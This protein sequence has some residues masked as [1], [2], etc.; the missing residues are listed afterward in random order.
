[1]GENS[2]DPL[3]AMEPQYAT[4]MINIFPKGNYGEVR[5][6][7][8]VHSSGMG[9]GAVATLA[10]HVSLTGSRKLIAAANGNIYNATT[11]NGTAS[12]LGSG[13]AS[14][15]W[16][17]VN[18]LANL[19]LVNGAD[20]PK[21][22]DGTS[23]TDAVYTGIADDSKLVDVC[24]FKE[25]LFFIEKDTTNFWYGA[26][27]TITGALTAFEVGDYLNH[28]G[29]LQSISS[30]TS[31]TGSGMQ[32]MLVLVS[33]EGEILTYSGIDPA[34]DF[35][36]VGRYK[37]PTPHG[38]RCTQNVG[39]DLF[40]L[41]QQGITSISQLVGGIDV[42]AGFKQ[43]TNTIAPTF[44]AASQSFGN[45]RNWEVF[46]Y[47]RGQWGMV[48]V[49][50]SSVSSYQ[51]VM[52]TE[53]GAWCQFRS[54][55]SITWCL[56]N[57]LPYFGGP[58]GKVY[59]ADVTNSD[60]SSAIN[61]FVRFAF[62]FFGDKTR[63]KLFHLASAQIIGSSNAR[64]SFGIDVDGSSDITTDTIEITTGQGSEWDESDWDVTSW[65]QEFVYSTQWEGIYG[66][67]RAAALKISGKFKDVA[68]KFSSAQVQF[69]VGGYL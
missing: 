8:R 36:L 2:R 12:S 45:N 5:R 64:L 42:S 31:N 53:T 25:R 7:Y 10:Q 47:P 44:A 68:I 13:Y 61:A 38:R 63:T 32:D 34:T 33:S 22:Y 56:F 21:K 6:G 55:P 3:L 60:N 27:G 19:I 26:A 16:Q 1:M 30:W 49:P 46:F 37:V 54:V 40:I 18:Y 4:S 43:F 50:A 29:Y 57:D 67:G 69:E 62:N 59:Q 52:N 48:N 66:N 35:E 9:S 24:V 14:N 65:G 11:Y 39:A 15:Y 17:T 20:Q 58:D 51:F 28:G 23:L 41:H